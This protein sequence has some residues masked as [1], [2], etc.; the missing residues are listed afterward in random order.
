MGSHGEL[1]TELEICFQNGFLK[2]EDCAES[3]RLL[4]R[5]G[6]MLTRLHDSL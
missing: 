6:A 5:V 3:L 1:D 4:E 2:R